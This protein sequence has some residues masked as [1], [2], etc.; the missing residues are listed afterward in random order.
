MMRYSFLSLLGNAL[1]GHQHWPRAWRDPAPKAAYDVIIVGAGGHGL[2]TAYYL[3]KNHG[4]TNVAVL[5]KGWLAGGNMARN[6]TIIRSNY[7]IDESAHLYEY[8]LKLWEGLSQELNYNTMFSARGIVSLALTGGELGEMRRRVNA[9]RLNGIDSEMMTPAQ[10]QREV[11]LLNLDRNARYPV[12][13]GMVQRRGGTA[14]HD[15]VAWGYA[16]GADAMGVDLIQNCAVTGIRR[17]GG[18]VVGVETTRGTIAASKIGLAAAG[19][20]GVVMAMAGQRLPIESFPIQAYVS[21]PIKPILDTVL[22]FGQVH[23]SVSQSDKGELVFG[24]SRENYLSYAQRGNP[25]IVEGQIATVLEL[26][27][28]AS[29][30]RMLRQWAGIVDCTP[31]ASPIIGLTP[32]EGLYL[33][34]GW[35]TGGFKSTPASGWVFAHTIARN[36]PHP[37]NAKFSLDRFRTGGLIDENAASSAVEQ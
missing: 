28:F 12:L 3:A 30:L 11:P 16:R 17:L 23:I 29:R 35:G 4:I 33:N 21:E 20:S 34:C 14:R 7:L 25:P 27:P 2:A 15:A 31:D 26:L 10:L 22:M 36:E 1:T 8:A 5:E 32:V 24:G 13:G 37:L 18:K 19:H 9:L 6:T